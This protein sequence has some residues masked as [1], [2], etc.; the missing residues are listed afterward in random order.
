MKTMLSG[1]GSRWMILL[2]LALALVACAPSHVPPAGH[3]CV[4][5]C[6]N[7]R[8]LGCLQDDGRADNGDECEEWYCET[9][10]LPP[11]ACVARASS[12]EAARECK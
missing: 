12:C 8:A 4:A 3:D 1:L 6:E 5:A 11:S 7:L 10:R 2:A 9:P